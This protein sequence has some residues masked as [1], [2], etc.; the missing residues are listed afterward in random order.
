MWI[1]ETDDS[2]TEGMTFRLPPGTVKTI[3]RSTGAEFIVEAPLVSRLHC[4]ITATGTSL[5]V[6]D[7]DST[8][9]TFV[10]DKPV[11]RHSLHE[12]DVVIIGKH[13][14][15]FTHA[16]GGQ[17]DEP[18][19]DVFL[20]ETDDTVPVYDA[21]V[22]QT[23]IPMAPGRIGILKV[24]AG[25]TGESEYT[26]SAMTTLVGKGA[27]SQIRLKGWFKPEVA[28]A[29]TRSGEGFSISPVDGKVTING[30]R[31]SAR[32]DLASGDVIAVSGLSLEFKF[33]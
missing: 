21:V 8:N 15:R 23:A 16:D 18:T 29:I 27:A 6:K 33:V 12:G 22:P 24:I 11:A 19:A 7:L 20:P 1:L 2:S 17:P 25:N 4:Q 26:L 5:Q 14:L 31:I 13:A 28:A 10:N 9:G 30:E 32:R 3:G